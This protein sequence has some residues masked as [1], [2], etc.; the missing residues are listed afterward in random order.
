[1]TLLYS[2][3][4]N[5]SNKNNNFHLLNDDNVL[6][7]VLA[8]PCSQK[9]CRAGIIIS[10]LGMQKLVLREEKH[11]V[12]SHTAG[13]RWDQD[14]SGGHPPPKPVCFSLHHTASPR[15]PRPISDQRTQWPHAQTV[16]P[17][18]QMTRTGSTEGGRASFACPL[19]T[20][21]F[22]AARR[23]LQVQ[24]SETR[25]KGGVGEGYPATSKGKTGGH[26]GTGHA[27]SVTPVNPEKSCAG[28]P[29]SDLPDL[30][31]TDEGW[32]QH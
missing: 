21:D 10:I 17:G 12:Q 2:N 27:T 26:H 15:C 20:H 19:N 31:R 28:A 13:M 24:S 8:A 29:A 18:T 30:Q 23:N 3:N 16:E 14:L 11:L 32:S 25:R 6:G 22:M 5:C 7:V 4:S 1:M 9:P